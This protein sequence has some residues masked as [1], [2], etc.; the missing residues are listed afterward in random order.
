MGVLSDS[1]NHIKQYKTGV[2]VGGLVGAAL[3]G[4]AEYQQSGGRVR[5]TAAAAAIGGALGVLIGS[6][7]AIGVGYA[8]G[9]GATPWTPIAASAGAGLAIIPDL[10]QII[11]GRTHS[12][13]KDLLK[14]SILL[15]LTGA[16]IGLS[17]DVFRG[18]M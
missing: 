14:R 5:D 7:V 3:L 16:A 11:T 15:G 9:M 8:R 4:F 18:Q 6:A 13:P 17:I 2:G 12:S 1:L 10:P